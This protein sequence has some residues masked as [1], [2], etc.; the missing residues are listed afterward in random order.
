[1]SDDKNRVSG[2]LQRHSE[3]V[4]Y[5]LGVVFFIY[6]ITALVNLTRGIAGPDSSNWIST[7]GGFIAGIAGVILGLRTAKD[8]REHPE[9]E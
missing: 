3:L 8:K 5:A 1:M 9:D 4:W 6:G 7:F 2:W